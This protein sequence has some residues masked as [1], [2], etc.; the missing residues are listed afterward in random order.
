MG[1]Y[2]ND[3]LVSAEWVTDRLTAFGR[4]DPEYVLVEVDADT[5]IYDEGHVPGAITFDWQE[6]LQDPTTFDVRSKSDFEEI[7][8]NAGITADSMVILYGDMMNW[9]AAYA[10][11]LFSYYGHNDLRILNG[12]RDYWQSQNGPMTTDRPTFTA[13][14]YEAAEPDLSIRLDQRE[15]AD[16]LDTTTKIVDVRTLQEYRGEILAPPGWNEGVQRGGHIPGAIN[17]PWSRTVRDDGR[18][19][20]ADEL[21]TLFEQEGVLET[22]SIVYCRIGERS[23]L[24]WVV[25]HELLGYENVA[26]YYGS[27]VEWGNTVG[28]PIEQGAS[29][30]FDV[31]DG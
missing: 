9:F 22:D 30:D 10:Y 21:R 19:K 1:S 28:A 11:W 17:I 5:S 2:A 24:V 14:S 4:D 6:E 16:A 23:A 18:F 25:L 15:V 3:I 8:G 20:P 29:T 27:W 12:G 7:V 26:H 31:T 13:R